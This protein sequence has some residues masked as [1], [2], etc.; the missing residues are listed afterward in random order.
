MN[1][2][3]LCIADFEGNFIKVNKSWETTLGYKT[4]ELTS[5]KF[6]EFVHPEDLQTTLDEMKNMGKKNNALNFVNR[7]RTKDG[8][9]RYIEWRS[10]P[11]GKLIYAAARDITEK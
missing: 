9:Y 5:S 4:D 3:L 10:K 7:Y 11:S 6:L 2:D 1:L 8:S